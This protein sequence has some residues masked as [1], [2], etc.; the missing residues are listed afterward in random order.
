[1]DII[2]KNIILMQLIDY[3]GISFERNI[4]GKVIIA[5]S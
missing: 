1:M 4:S 2:K 3:Q 5:I